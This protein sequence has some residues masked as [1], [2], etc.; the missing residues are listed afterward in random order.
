MALSITTSIPDPIF[1]PSVFTISGS[2]SSRRPQ[3][4][5][6]VLG[7]EHVFASGT[8]EAHI[9]QREAEV[10]VERAVSLIYSDQNCR[11]ASPR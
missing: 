2:W 3:Q 5:D 11:W 8:Y 1:Q 6:D 9:N 10:V 7:V 4:V